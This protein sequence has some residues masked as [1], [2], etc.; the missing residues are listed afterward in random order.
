M[1][2][3]CVILCLLYLASAEILIHSITSPFSHLGTKSLYCRRSSLLMMDLCSS[4][5]S[6]DDLSDKTIGF[7]GC[8]KISSAVCR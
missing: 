6:D 5:S 4:S 1:L 7:L 8:G 2:Y 3:C